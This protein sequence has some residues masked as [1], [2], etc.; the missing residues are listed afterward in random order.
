[1]KITLL[2][3]E[4]RNFKKA[5]NLTIK[6]SNET[7]ISADNGVGKTTIFDAFTWLLFGKSSSDDKDFNIKTLD[8][9]NNPIHR[10]EH[11]VEGVLDIDGVH[12]RFTRT[13]KEKWVKKK[14]SEDSEFNGH[15][16]TYF[17][18]HVPISA[19]EFKGRVEMFINENIFKMITSPVH[20]NRMKWEDRRAILDTIA[21]SPSNIDIAGES[22]EFKKFLS[23]L[24]GEKIIDYKKRIGAQKKKIKEQLDEIPSRVSE[25]N[26]T[27][28]ADPNYTE[29]EQEIT[30]K[31]TDVLLIEKSIESSLEAIKG[32]IKKATAAE[33]T[34]FQMESNLTTMQNAS[35]Q[36]KTS[37]ISRIN[38]KI[39]G[40]QT[41]IKNRN[42]D[43]E[44][45]ER[46]MNSLTVDMNAVENDNKN[47]RA[48]F[49]KINAE[50][51]ILN[52]TEC[53][54]P[55]C[56]REIENVEEKKKELEE[57]FNKDKIDR[58]NKIN[59]KG[60][61]NT[62]KIADLKTSFSLQES[63]AKE[64]KTKNEE[65]EKE[66]TELKTHV[67]ALEKAPVQESEEEKKL[68]SDIEAFIIPTVVPPDNT[69]LK[70][71]KAEI[72]KEIDELEKKL[73]IKTHNEGVA[74]RI[75]ELEASEKK[76]NQELANLERKEFIA[77]DFNKKKITEIERR[78]NDKFG[79]VKW[80]M[81]EPQINGGESEICECM[82][83]G[84]PFSDLNTAAKINA[85]IDIINALCKHYNISAP[86]FVDN[87]ESVSK[88]LP[89]E[90]QIINLIKVEG[91]T[92][93]K[94][95]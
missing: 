42:T 90:S 84:V 41:D 32:E 72:E 70:S 24:A 40:L 45:A 9:K 67:D 65:I 27:K 66:I 22:E 46:N 61:T 36:V 39:S 14:G 15:E 68:K 31:K 5:H 51:F 82:V 19:T 28:K 64:D 94:I 81:F 18:N 12:C 54:C 20:F 50:V 6:F 78:V 86:I 48:D 3:L 55:T 38:T 89:C 62:K 11:T 60:K 53:K 56:K 88:L 23:E 8:G 26:L 69:A 29:V 80:K 71:K 16:T 91:L 34:K 79:Y 4:L 10:L 59:E 35:K 63:I 95:N 7:N 30:K 17:Y 43:I 74:K 44:R 49:S 92:E 77:A 87:R 25:V 73:D 75:A 37:D 52:E 83:N 33:Q 2:S 76:L 47:L 58:L 85:G 57:N 21:G 13:Y 93:L 1:M